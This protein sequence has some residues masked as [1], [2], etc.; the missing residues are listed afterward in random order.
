MDR[1]IDMPVA[2]GEISAAIADF[3][4]DRKIAGQ[5]AAASPG[6]VL[7]HEHA[8]PGATFEPHQRATGRIV[9]DCVKPLV[10]GQAP[11]RDRTVPQ[12]ILTR[13]GGHD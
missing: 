12:A 8:L 7:A 10:L 2:D 6:S 5:I 3:A 1:E 4:A 9:P 11:R 13:F